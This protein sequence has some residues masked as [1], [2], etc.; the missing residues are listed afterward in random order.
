MG[1][2]SQTQNASTQ[3]FKQNSQSG[4][5]NPFAPAQGLLS[6]ASRVAGDQFGNVSLTPTENSALTGLANSGSYSGQFAPQQTSLVNDLYSGGKDYS[7][8]VTGARD[9]YL[10]Q[11]DPTISGKFLDPSTNPFFGQTVSTI[12]NDVTNRLKSLYAGAGRSPAN[13]GNFGYNLARGI[14][15][16][17]APTFASAYNQE[18]GNQL[19]A[20]G[21]AFNA[22]NT[23]TGLLSG[24]DQT[25]LGNRQAAAGAATT[26]QDLTSA[27]FLSQLA[28]EAQRR[29]IP[30]STLS[31]LVS[32][33]TALGG[34]GKTFDVTGASSGQGTSTGNTTKQYGTGDYID[35]GLKL[36]SLY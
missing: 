29:G 14:S 8:D 16:G 27:P 31:Q 33:A 30:Q 21:N 1:N 15:E 9:K 17:T 36:A 6:E 3:E 7:G 18:R 34:A 23:A 12:G 26:G 24:L 11:L 20:M 32:I 22:G 5:V 10:S 35:M 4:T 25:R 28:A 19:N 2:P 13:A